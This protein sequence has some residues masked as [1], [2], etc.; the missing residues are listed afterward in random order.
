MAHGCWNANRNAQTGIDSGRIVALSEETMKQLK[1]GRPV[2]DKSGNVLALVRGEKGRLQHVMRL[3]RAGAQA[4]VASNVATLA[5]TAALSQQLEHIEQ[6][7]T[8]IRATLDGLV[9]DID[10]GRLATAVASNKVLQ[11]VADSVRRRGEMTDADWDLLA[12]ISLPVAANS[13]EAEAKFAEIAARLDHGIN[14]AERVEELERLRGKERLEYWLAMRVEADLAQSRWDLLQLYWEQTQHR[15]PRRRQREADR[16]IERGGVRLAERER[17]AAHDSGEPPA[18]H[19]RGY[20]G[21]VAGA[22]GSPVDVEVLERRELLVHRGSEPVEDR[23]QR[24]DATAAGWGATSAAAN[25]SGAA[26]SCRRS[27]AAP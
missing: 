7:L 8:Q 6:Q 24:F 3:D 16:Q 27:S 25:G 18:A 15:N 5:V 22:Q 21:P 2:Y 13:A 10:R 20:L 9:A 14:R 26:P 1:T 19:A 23:R 17:Q 12:S 11:T 4:V